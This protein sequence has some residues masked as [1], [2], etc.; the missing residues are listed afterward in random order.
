MTHLTAAP[1][2]PS[3]AAPLQTVLMPSLTE[4][5]LDVRTE[6]RTAWC[7][8]R[9]QGRPSFTAA[10]LDDLD[11]VQA[12]IAHL[13]EARDQ[14]GQRAVGWVVLASGLPGVF[15]LGG[16]LALFTALI[17]GRDEAGLR[18]YAYACVRVGHAN[19]SGYGNRTVTIGLAQGDALGGGFESLLSCHVL[20][21]ER[22]A[23]FGL[24][25]VLFGLFPGMGAHPFLTRRVGAARAHA[26]ITSGAQFTAEEL[27]GQGIVDVLAEDGEGEQ[28]VH[29]YIARHDRSHAAHLAIH[30]AGRAISP[31]TLA[32][33]QEIADIWVETAMCLTEQDR[34]RMAR[35]A[36]AQDRLKRRTDMISP[37]LHAY[38][39]AWATE[40]RQAV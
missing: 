37:P 19:W 11:R 20:V 35:I 31:V 38:P 12:C 13:A 18:A 28:A 26:M 14:G 7:R 40:G 36:S 6:D 32:G 16:D 4:A 23:R 24:P 30:R 5:V 15:S 8:L 22:R 10:L 3:T 2:R 29:D 39:P 33:L 27:H 34:K 9:P 21:A 25:E 17:E 1:P